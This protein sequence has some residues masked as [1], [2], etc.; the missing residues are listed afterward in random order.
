MHCDSS[1]TR[2]ERNLPINSFKPIE[3]GN[4]KATL[5]DQVYESLRHAIIHGHLSPGSR[6]N[7]ID[8]ARNLNVSQRTVREALAKLISEGLVSREPYKEFRVVGLSVEEMEEILHMRVLLEGWAMELAACEISPDELNQ[9]RELLAQM[10]A[11]SGPESVITLQGINSDFHWIA[12]NACKKISLIQMLKLLWDLML[13]YSLVEEVTENYAEQTR[14]TQIS[15]RQLIEALESRNAHA[16]RKI[17]IRHSEEAMAQV[18][19]QVKKMNK[20]EA[21]DNGSLFLQRLLPIRTSFR[22]SGPGNLPEEREDS[23]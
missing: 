4:S 17:L 14:K 2:A 22:N 18:R 6:L 10:E 13:P 3:R 19:A 11:S 8:T 16:A 20:L 7:Q 5:A 12:I 9:M 21:R 15:H 1:R 23:V